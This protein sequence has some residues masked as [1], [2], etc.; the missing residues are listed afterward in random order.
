MGAVSTSL[1]LAA[2][3]LMPLA[4]PA[5]AAASNGS[6]AFSTLMADYAHTFTS[7]GHSDLLLVNDYPCTLSGN[8]ACT[9]A[10]TSWNYWW[11][12]HGL[13]A[14]LDDAELSGLE[15]E[16]TSTDIQDAEQLVQG[17]SDTNAGTGCNSANALY[18]C[19]NDDMAW[20]GLAVLRLWDFTGT[21]AYLTDAEDLFQQIWS[22]WG[23]CSSPGVPWNRNS[24]CGK[25]T[26]ANATAA[27]LGAE[28]YIRTRTV[29]YLNDAEALMAFEEQYLVQG[30]GEVQDTV[31]FNSNG[32][33]SGVSGTSGGWT[34][35]QG[36]AIGAGAALY[37]AEF[38]AQRG[39]DGV[40]YLTAA[41]QVLSYVLSEWTGPLPKGGANGG[42]GYGTGGGQGDCGLFNGILIRYAEQLLQLDG[43]HTT[44]YNWLQTNA[45]D[46]YTN[47]QSGNLYGP[48]WTGSSGNASSYQ[49]L[50]LSTDLSGVYVENVSQFVGSGESVYEGE[51]GLLN[52]SGVY[53]NAAGY[54]GWGF[55]GGWNGT[56]QYDEV[57]PYLHSGG[58]YQLT[59][60]YSAAA[61]TASRNLS[62]NGAADGTVSFPSTSGWGSWTTVS[63][64]VTLDAGLNTVELEA[65]DGVYLNIDQYQLTC[66]SGCATY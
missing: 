13:M 59:F 55:V 65:S 33:V 63:T 38:K 37:L 32:T 24:P 44:L 3:L 58:T 51:D 2:A 18:R 40:P 49:P 46:A 5:P 36:V 62:V 7:G 4:V 21:S 48:D 6:S 30:S 66:V 41:N 26:A 11:E 47:A 45:S 28:L 53:Q 25:N 42:C 20:M 10:D 17:I 61:G 35:D 64:D 29:G 31:T 23:G 12:A 43:T 27:I 57:A 39:Y 52:F 54:S 34:Y 1:A 56:G 16:P 14:I 15:D 50:D 19:Y 9:N 8:Y 22:S 60:R